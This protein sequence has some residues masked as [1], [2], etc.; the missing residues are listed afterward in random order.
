MAAKHRPTPCRTPAAATL[1][2]KQTQR[3]PTRSR[4]RRQDPPRHRHRASGLPARAQSALHQCRRS[5]Q[6][7]HNRP[8][9]RTTQ[10]RHAALHRTAFARTRGNRL[11]THRQNRR[12]SAL[13]DHQR[14]LRT[15]GD[16][17]HYQQSLQRLA[18]HLQ[19]R[20]YS[21]I[22]R[23]RPTLTPLRNR[24][25]PRLQLQNAKNKI[26][27]I[28]T[29]TKKNKAGKSIFPRLFCRGLSNRPYHATFTPPP[30]ASGLFTRKQ[31][32][33]NQDLLICGPRIP[34]RQIQTRL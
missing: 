21:H 17:A 14:P 28:I 15:R 34:T 18:Q 29:L 12:R 2:R 32:R 6:R 4:R 16:P 8:K 11:S 33:A 7:P 31:R 23:P 24:H 22:R 1:R 20:Q 27:P 5:H 26:Y 13:P 10:T 9:I 30:T 25:H 19:Q 3:R